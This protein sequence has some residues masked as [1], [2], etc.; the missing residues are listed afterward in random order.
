MS[1]GLSLFYCKKFKILERYFNKELQ[2][3]NDSQSFTYFT[4][5]AKL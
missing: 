2:K 1:I 5:Q 4:S 3:L